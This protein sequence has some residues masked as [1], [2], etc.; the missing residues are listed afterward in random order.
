[1]CLS[2]T[3]ATVWENLGNGE[4]G[5]GSW[6][7]NKNFSILLLCPSALS[8]RTRKYGLFY[9]F[10]TEGILKRALDILSIFTRFDV[11]HDDLLNVKPDFRLPTRT[12]YTPAV[13]LCF[14]LFAS[15]DFEPLLDL[16]Q[17][18]II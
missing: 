12:L 1:V 13:T 18:V 3:G 17:W 7:I 10:P 4:L 16:W 9:I 11:S 8:S 5:V 2:A 14:I 15:L 6:G